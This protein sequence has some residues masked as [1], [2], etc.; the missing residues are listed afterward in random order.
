MSK[1]K[2]LLATPNL[3][4]FFIAIVIVSVI[5]AGITMG[6][7]Y[8]W[9]ISSNIP[10]P[11]PYTLEYIGYQSV[12]FGVVNGL[13]HIGFRSK[14]HI[15]S[16]EYLKWLLVLIIANIVICYIV[17]NI[18]I[19]P[20]I[21]EVKRLYGEAGKVPR[22]LYTLSVPIGLF[23]AMFCMVGIPYFTWRKRTNPHQNSI[24][25]YHA[26]TY[27]LIKSY[28]IV[29][30][31]ILIVNLTYYQFYLEF[32]GEIPKQGFSIGVMIQMAFVLTGIAAML[33]LY[34]R[35]NAKNGLFFYIILT[36]II[37]YSAFLAGL[38]R[39]NGQPL[40]DNTLWLN[41]PIAV[42]S[43]IGELVGIPF[44]FKNLMKPKKVDRYKR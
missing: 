34:L 11:D 13:I 18:Q 41:I 16:F 22:E 9:D 2:L 20:S 30:T 32:G 24:K 6:Y 10:I 19:M 1:S 26:I 3:F 25:E 29:V 44:F 4:D 14:K 21:N 15:N 33:F 7:Y 28:L 8:L 12:F 43:A 40:F 39:E 35:D 37:S 36:V 17:M 38:S 42:V 23:S 31:L 5:T 27:R